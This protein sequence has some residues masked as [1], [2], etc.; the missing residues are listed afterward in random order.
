[1]YL[2]RAG[3]RLFKGGG[4]TPQENIFISSSERKGTKHFIAS[5][6]LFKV[7]QQMS[8]K[9]D[10]KRKILLLSMKGYRKSMYEKWK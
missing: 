1:M 4:C 6:D 5:Q 2:E 10:F 3:F 7:S 8:G 9:K